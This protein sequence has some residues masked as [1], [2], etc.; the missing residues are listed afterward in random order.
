MISHLSGLC[1]FNTA[2]V[3]RHPL[4]FNCKVT[5]AAF[6]LTFPSAR[7]GRSPPPLA[8][9]QLPQQSFGAGTSLAPILQIGKRRTARL[10]ILPK[11]RSRRAA[12]LQRPRSQHSLRRGVKSTLDGRSSGHGDASAA[13]SGR[14]PPSYIRAQASATDQP[15]TQSHFRTYELDFSGSQTRRFRILPPP[16]RKTYAALRPRSPHS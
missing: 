14:R 6:Q 10:S 12:R 2:I 13:N 15:A 16:G 4:S 8:S 5:S 9:P 7:P 3:P 1:T 11:G